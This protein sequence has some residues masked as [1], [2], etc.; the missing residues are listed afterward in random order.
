VPSIIP[1]ALAAA[2]YPTLLAGV[3]VLLARDKPA[4]LLAG[5][6]A[7]GVAIS[8]SSGLIIVFA[9][10]G[11]VSTKSQRSASPTVDLIVGVLSIALAGGLYERRRRRGAGQATAKPKRKK[12]GPSWTQQKLGEGSVWAAFGAGL[13]LNL[14]GIWYLD[15]LKEI[16]AA[17][18]AT[19][20]TI[21]S[22]L[23]F[24]VIMFALAELPLVGYLVSP[25]G[26]RVRVQRFR[27]W[28]VENGPAIGIWAAGLIGAYLTI[29]GI[30]G[31][32]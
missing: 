2:V 32:A 19:V 12:D 1:L 29:K 3:I 13:V 8:L 11:A 6:L 27:G 18:E 17:N 21:L 14:P 15:A 25:E 31:L 10:D 9:L 7:G 20:P 22:I 16:G 28:L 30:V 24:I 4:P 23:L 5:F 26:T